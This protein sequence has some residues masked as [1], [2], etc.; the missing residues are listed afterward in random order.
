MSVYAAPIGSFEVSAP[1]VIVG[2][3]AAGLCAALSAHESGVDVVVVERIH[4]R[5]GRRLIPAAG[6]RF[7]RLAGVS[8]SAAQFA[9]DIRRKA[10]DEPDDTIIDTIARESGTTEW[11]ASRYSFPFS[12]VSDFD[13]PGHS[14]RRMHGLPSRSG[15]ELID[16]LRAAVDQEAI[17]IVVNARVAGLFSDTEC[18]IRG[19]EVI[20]PDGKQDGIGCKALI[21]ACNGYG[22]AADLVARYIPEMRGAHYFGHLGNCGD[23]V[24]WGQE[25]GAKLL[26]MSGYQGHGSVAHPHGILITW[27]VIMEGGFQVNVLGQ[28][29]SDES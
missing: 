13:Y 24:L 18:V 28:R 14:V 27:A 29:F 25:L 2:A 17:P 16:R 7:Q 10:H 23:A 4:C 19:V 21:L 20:W 8:D 3:G 22:G 1:V 6:T 9:A 12:L 5:E 15:V 26:H 11:L